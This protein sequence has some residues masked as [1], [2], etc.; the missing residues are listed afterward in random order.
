VLP[1]KNNLL[2]WNKKHGNL[3]T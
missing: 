2:N 3:H 1:Y